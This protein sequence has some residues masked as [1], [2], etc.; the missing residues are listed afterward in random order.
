MI[1]VAI[2]GG[3]ISG[4][5]MAI[6]CARAGLKTMILEKDEYPKHK[7]CGE[8]I[9]NESKEYLIKLGVSIEDL[10]LPN[11]SKFK[12]TTYHGNESDCELSPGGFGLSRFMLDRLLAERAIA[13]G[14][15]V[16]TK[17]KV[18]KIE[19]DF[20]RGFEIQT[21]KN[22]PIKARLVIG[23]WGRS[24]ALNQG[25]A[26]KAKDA[27][28]GVKYHLSE[29]PP[30]DTIEIHAFKD[31]YCGI[32]KIEDEKFCLC[33]LAKASGLKEYKASIIDFEKHVLAENPFLAERLKAARIEGPVTTSQF[34]FGVNQSPTNQPLL[35]DASGF[36]PP[37]TGN[38][39]SLALRSTKMT[40]PYVLDLLQGNISY[41]AFESGAKSYQ[42]GYLNRRVKQGIL[43]QDLLFM[44]P[45]GLNKL[46]MS[47]F[48][49][50]PFAL[51]TMT[52]LA[53]GKDL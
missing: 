39:M 42:A 22:E 28:I 48:A 15:Q 51:K 14:A 34:Y 5:S 19:G 24:N 12:L 7:V 33:Y 10:N 11:I 21:Q 43:L 2:I 49:V 38:G 30:S 6:H 47:A 18:V 44:K 17:T 31:G 37:L 35:G 40:F 53:V 45:E 26:P 25:P 36:I 41:H 9:S 3:G 50:A 1:D 16:K 46:M 29:G 20:E 32:S 13:S 27:W 8:Y 23:A 52:K 4:L